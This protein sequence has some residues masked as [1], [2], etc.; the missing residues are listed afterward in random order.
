MSKRVVV[1]P[2]TQ[3]KPGV[4]VEHLEWISSY[5]QAI[6]PE[7]IIHIGDHFDMPSLSSYDKGTA[8]AE[9]KRYV[10]DILAGQDGLRVLNR[11][12]RPTKTWKPRKVFLMGNHEQRVVRFANDNPNMIG[13]VGPHSFK[14]E[15]FGWDV[16]PFLKPFEDDNINYVHY[17]ANPMTGKPYTGKASGIL[18]RC[19]KSFVMGHRQELDIATRT[20]LGGDM[21]V[22]IVAGACYLH[23]EGYK[24][25]QGN[26]HWRGIIVLNDVHDGYG[27]IMPV[28]LSYLERKHG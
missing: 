13:T 23:D 4:R 2:D 9:N 26:N 14:L 3:V 17:V 22:G 6:K 21:Q 24:G 18:Q 20:I 19:G 16:K 15:N 1:I 12:I 10:D 7:L 5:I 11:H 25:F 8:A 27:D 28:S